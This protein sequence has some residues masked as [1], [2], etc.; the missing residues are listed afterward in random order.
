MEE[1]IP[2][3]PGHAS[4]AHATREIAKHETEVLFILNDG[5]LSGMITES[6]IVRKVIA[7]GLDPASILISDIMKT[8]VV[9][10]RS[11]APIGEACALL[12]Q[13]KIRILPVVNSNLEP[14]GIVNALDLL[15]FF[16]NSSEF[17]EI[18]TE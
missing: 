5:K 6:D 9:C 17:G 18:L 1:R 7:Q 15:F 12:S 2:L 13:E 16:E 14:E 10:I 3:V 11:G 4:V 8:E